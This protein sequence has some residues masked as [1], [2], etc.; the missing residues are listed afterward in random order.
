MSERH[1]IGGGGDGSHSQQAPPM[2]LPV[3]RL[4]RYMRVQ[5][6]VSDGVLRWD[7]PRT[8]LGLVPIGVRHIAIPVADVQSLRVHRA[9]RP[10]NL[11]VGVLCIAV[12]LVL[13]LWWIAVPMLILGVWVILVSLGPRLDVVTCAGAKD[14]ANVCFSHQLDAELYMAAV[15]DL[16]EQARKGR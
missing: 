7:V 14:H 3:H 2:T 10:F 6:E 15:S 9:A 4:A 16:A 8:L 12:P 13:G 5:L 11:V 1:E